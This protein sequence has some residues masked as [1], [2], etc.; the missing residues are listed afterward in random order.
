MKRF[1]AAGIWINASE[2]LR[3]ELFFNPL[4]RAKYVD[5]GWCFPPP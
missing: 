5:L 3:N 4:W 2:F 1:A